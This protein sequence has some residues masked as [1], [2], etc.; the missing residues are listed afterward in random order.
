MVLQNALKILECLFEY[1]IIR[2][3]FSYISGNFAAVTA[4]WAEWN[5]KRRLREIW[6]KQGEASSKMYILQF[7]RYNF[8]KFAD[9]LIVLWEK[10]EFFYIYCE[11]S[12]DKTCIYEYN[13][14]IKHYDAKFSLISRRRKDHEIFNQTFC[15]CSFHRNDPWCF[16]PYLL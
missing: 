13:L 3:R 9:F 11:K 15:S 12:V 4:E 2:H 7:M 8:S 6:K 10:N 16:Q 14:Y 1:C 5:E